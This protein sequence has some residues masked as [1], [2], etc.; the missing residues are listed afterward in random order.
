MFVQSSRRVR[1]LKTIL[2]ATSVLALGGT[3]YSYAQPANQPVET[4]VV[5]GTHLIGGFTAPTP[6]T[7]QD[8]ATIQERAPSTISDVI[9]Q[10]PEMRQTQTNTQAPRGNGAGGQN[11]VDLRGLGTSRTLMLMDGI[12]FVPTNIGGSIDIN[13]I[14]TLLVSRVEVVTGGASAAYGSDA[15]SGVINFIMKDRFEGVQGSFQY[16]ESELG[17]NIEPAMSFAAGANIFGDRLHVVIGGDFSDN[18]GVGTIYS[19]PNEYGDK[20]PNGQW[21][22]V[23]N[24][25]NHAASGQPA[26]SLVPDCTWSTQA[27][28]SVIVAAKTNTGAA[29]NGLNQVAF[30]PNG[31]P[32]NFQP[33][34]VASTLMYGGPDNPGDPH[35]NP[36]GNWLIEAP[37]KRATA[38]GKFTFDLDDDTSVY[39][40]YNYG[41][42]SQQGLSTFHQETN[43]IIPVSGPFANPFVPASIQAIANANNLASITVGKQEEALGGY[44]FFQTDVVNRA[45]I[46]ARGKLFADWSWDIDWEH[47]QTQESSNLLSNILEGNYLE[48]IFAVAGPNGVPV[49]GPV[50]NN[51]NLAMGSIGAG[52]ASQVQPGCSPFNI[53]GPTVQAYNVGNPPYASANDTLQVLSGGVASPAAI[54]YIAH[55]TNNIVMVQQD[56]IDINVHGVPFDDWAGPVAVAAGFSHRRQGASSRTDAFGDAAYSLSNNGSTY[57]GSFEVN[58]G[59]VE[60]GVPLLKDAPFAQDMNTDIA[61]RVTDYS[62]SGTRATWKVGV[63]DQIDPTV[64]F[65]ATVSRDV[66]EPSIS[67]LFSVQTLGITA[68]FSNPVTGLSG[69]EYTLSGGN[70]NLKPEVATSY[71]AGFVFTPSAAWLEGFNVSVDYYNTTIKGA[72]GSVSAANTAT[73]CAQHIQNDFYCQFMDNLGP[74]GALRIRT[75]SANLN[76]QLTDGMDFEFDYSVPQDLFEAAGLPGSLRIRWLTTWV[77]TLATTTAVSRLNVAGSG[78]GGGV[79]NWTSN[80]NLLYGWGPTTT[81][82]QLRYTSDIKADAT[83]IGPGQEGYSPALSNSISRN[84]FPAQVYVDLAETLSLGNVAGADVQA[85]F[86]VNNVLDKHAPG[87]GQAL[88]A[89]VT[90]GDPYD[91]IGRTYKVGVRYKF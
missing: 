34:T 75:Q 16:G 57:T 37:H 66:R 62:L 42:N 12:R 14:P 39:L 29:Y 60:F 10:L 7:V 81:N 11:S 84:L 52:R 46:G 64:R 21:C 50:A 80:M 5:T 78:I 26:I 68:S 70:P 83:L 59:Y 74:G 9:N 15:V 53:F 82:I 36:N 35:G 22:S 4:V 49:C 18:H 69:P 65:R 43:I 76:K 79:P 67:D 19:R 89:F 6:V 27:A 88:V 38:Y 71:V 25:A 2:L 30:G 32:Y 56:V 45:V 20:T 17:D 55:S 87:V 3:G 28:G 40:Q 48:A 13:L 91:L 33:G 73:Y 61:V 86:N 23:V 85:F 51:P 72:I 44:Q 90:G 1:Q 58:E 63:S 47:G 8:A 31:V 54:N 41:Q 77:N 24:P